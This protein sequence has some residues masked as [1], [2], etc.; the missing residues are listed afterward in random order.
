MKIPKSE[1]LRLKLLA[2]ANIDIKLMNQFIESFQD[3]KNRR[4]R[5]VK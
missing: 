5:R 2:E 3:I 4:V 1:Y